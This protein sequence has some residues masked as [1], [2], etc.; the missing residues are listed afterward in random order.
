MID[1]SHNTD[2]VALGRISG[3]TQSAKKKEI[4]AFALAS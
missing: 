3:F 4:E 2:V 1:G